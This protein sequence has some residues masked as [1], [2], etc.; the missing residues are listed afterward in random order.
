[1]YDSPI[2]TIRDFHQTAKALTGLLKALRNPNGLQVTQ[3]WKILHMI[4]GE[5]RK[6]ADLIDEQVS[7]AED[8][9]E[10]SRNGG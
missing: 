1:M 4:A 10:L 7:K 3:T 8:L 6:L 2:Y 9:E 5:L